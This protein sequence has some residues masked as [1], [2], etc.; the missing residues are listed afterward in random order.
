MGLTRLEA[1]K[2]R[3]AAATPGKYWMAA[4][5]NDATFLTHVIADVSDLVQ[6]VEL[7]E[8]ALRFSTAHLE[9][10]EN[11]SVVSGTRYALNEALAKGREILKP[12]GGG[13]T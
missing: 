11:Y 9:S 3:L 1:I 8:A 13:D 12:G 5:L 2:A 7:Y 10:M 6:V 4:G